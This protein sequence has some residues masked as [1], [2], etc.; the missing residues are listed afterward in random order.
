MIGQKSSK[1]QLVDLDVDVL[2]IGGG[3]GGYCPC[4]Y[5]FCS[6]SHC[7]SSINAGRKGTGSAHRSFRLY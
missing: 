4:L 2:I 3:P 5:G 1:S 6:H 7:V